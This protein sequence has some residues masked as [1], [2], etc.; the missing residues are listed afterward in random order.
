MPDEAGLKDTVQVHPNEVV[1][2]IARFEDF[3]GTFV[4]HCHILEHEDHDMMRQFVTVTDCGDGARGLPI[5]ECDDGDGDNSDSCPDG[6]D[7]TC[8]PAFCGDGH[9]WNRDGGGEACDDGGESASCNADCTAVR[10]GDGQ[11]NES[12]GEVCDP[13]DAAVDC[14]AECSIDAGTSPPATRPDESLGPDATGGDAGRSMGDAGDDDG[15]GGGCGCR[16]DGHVAR[17][18]PR[19]PSLAMAGLLALL[20]RRRAKSPRTP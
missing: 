2:V 15:G 3:A 4:Y 17:D 16:V 8:Q 14:V 11:V 10:C 7:G 5:E 1:R 19:L 20:W 6:Q 9:V 13:G 18:V 12:A